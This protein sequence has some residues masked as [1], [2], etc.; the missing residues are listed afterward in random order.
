MSDRP[1]DDLLHQR[2][3]RRDALRL[4]GIG[5]SLAALV[6][7]CGSDRSGDTAP[8]RVGYA[9]PVTALPDYPV[10][11]A[12]YLRTSSSIEAT[13][14]DVYN[15]MLARS[16]VVDTTATAIQE[17]VARHEELLTQLTGLTEQAGGTAWTCSNPWIVDRLV[18]P[19]T[20]LIDTS[21][22]P[23]RDMLNFAIALEN[24]A[25][26]THQTYTSLLTQADLRTGLASASSVDARNAATLVTVAR[27]EDG[28][29]S[30]AING[31][32]TPQTDGIPDDFAIA[33]RFGSVAQFDL[34]LGPPDENGGREDFTINVPADNGYIYNELEP[35]C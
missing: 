35:S 8:G 32:E 34:I 29:V 17:L 30:P 13:I 11:D 21:D 33:F 3:G 6:A 14:I 27:G 20:A 26:A 12:V 24:L 28:Y 18:D 9:P 5:V 7:A 31:G 15:G 1:V 10:D 22:D 2:V 16:G 25:A 19:V 4:G 23:G